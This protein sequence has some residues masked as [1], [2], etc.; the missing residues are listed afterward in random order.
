MSN[1]GQFSRSFLTSSSSSSSSSSEDDLPSSATT[2]NNKPPRILYTPNGDQ[3]LE[4]TIETLMGTNFE[5]RLPAKTLVASIKNRLQRS[6]GVPR[7]HL[8]IIHSGMLLACLMIGGLL[9]HQGYPLQVLNCL[10]NAA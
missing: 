4:L 7:H 9:L 5:V 2:T 1:K 6:E 10:M 3:I 8:H